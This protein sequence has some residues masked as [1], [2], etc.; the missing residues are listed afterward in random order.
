MSA[1]PKS[2]AARRRQIE[3]LSALLDIELNWAADIVAEVEE[4]AAFARET[5]A[6]WNSPE[7]LEIRRADSELDRII[8]EDLGCRGVRPLDDDREGADET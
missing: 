2:V 3:A 1:R 4:Q 5:I 6:Y 8:I 7:G